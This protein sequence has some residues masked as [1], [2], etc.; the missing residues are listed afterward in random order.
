MSPN[1]PNPFNP[2]TTLRY[3]LPQSGSV[4]LTIYDMLGQEIRALVNEVQAPGMYT[5][6]W[7]GRND[8]GF[9]VASG[10]YFYRIEVGNFIQTRKMTLVR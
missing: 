8:H 3:A 5:V 10:L 4:K 9:A 6:L 1:F 7:N 2:E